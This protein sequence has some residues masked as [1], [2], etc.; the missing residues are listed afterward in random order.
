[1]N[2]T[3]DWGYG[4]PNGRIEGTF[5]MRIQDRADLV[6]V[7]FFIDETVVS[8]DTEPPFR[9]QF[10]T[11]DYAPGSHT[12]AAEGTLADGAILSSNTL[13]C[14]FL[15]ADEARGETLGFVV[16]LLGGIVTF[17]AI[18]AV[19]SLVLGRRKT[20]TPGRYSAA[21]GAICP[22]CGFP[23][24]R[25]ILSPNMLTGKL[26]RCPHCGKWAVVPRANAKAL[27][28]AEARLANREGTADFAPLDEQEK[29]R[30]LLDDSRYEG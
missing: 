18:A 11:S 23:Y 5:S 6:E 24:S 7:R 12:L 1:M 30:K 27:V 21:G 17:I 8:V 2:L 19:G 29:L 16:P 26:E 25:G 15:S 4:G 3:R 28:E 14:N 13:E 10:Q 9:F 20:F 22:R